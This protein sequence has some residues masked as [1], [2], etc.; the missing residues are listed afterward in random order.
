MSLKLHVTQYLEPKVYEYE[1]DLDTVVVIAMDGMVEC[2]FAIDRI[3]DKEGK[4]LLDHDGILDY[5]FRNN[6]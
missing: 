4:T 3:T 1:A 6:L 5:A 2:L